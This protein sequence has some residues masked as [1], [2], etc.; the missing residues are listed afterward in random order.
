M[1]VHKSAGGVVYK[2]IQ[3]DLCFLL[4]KHKEGHWGFPK[5]H[6]ADKITDESVEQ[7]AVREVREEGGVTAK[8]VN[9]LSVDTSYFFTDSDENINKK[10]VSYFLMEYVSGD[11]KDH[12]NEV[13]EAKFIKENEVWDTLT[14]NT[15]K[16]AFANI[17]EMKE[18]IQ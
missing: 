8:I 1:Q 5:G 7:A 2:K 14:Y 9:D 12:D 13:T 11:T 18:S 3:G 4:V 17:I 16:E 10:Y 15:D 6:I